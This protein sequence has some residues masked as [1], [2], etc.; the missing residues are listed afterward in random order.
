MSTATLI[1][2]VKP[3]F[4][5]HLDKLVETVGVPTSAVGFNCTPC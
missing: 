5:P 2:A 1:R 3:H 4:S